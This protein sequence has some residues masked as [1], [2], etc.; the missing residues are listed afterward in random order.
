MLAAGDYALANLA[1]DASPEPAR[2]PS[3]R[4]RAA[5]DAMS[6]GPCP[7]PWCYRLDDSR[8]VTGGALSNGQPPRLDAGY[9]AFDAA[10][11]GEASAHG[12][13]GSRPDVHASPGRGRSSA[14]RR[15]R[16]ARSPASPPQP[17]PLTSRAPASKPSPSNAL[18]STGVSTARRLGH[19]TWSRAARRFWARRPGCR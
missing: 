4:R 5:T 10:L 16:P 17:L 18:G 14:T 9:A 1:V 19:R 13:G 11:E 6:R 7:G 15:M 12:S 3:K 2:S 8:L